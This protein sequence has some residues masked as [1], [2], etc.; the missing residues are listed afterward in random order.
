MKTGAED[1]PAQMAMAQRGPIFSCRPLVNAVTLP[2][3]F[4][5]VVTWRFM[6]RWGVMGRL[7]IWGARWLHRSTR[8]EA[9]ERREAQT[10]QR[11]TSGVGVNLWE[12]YVPRPQCG[13]RAHHG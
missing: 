8:G 1:G 2:S 10:R 13:T 12:G 6:V 7:G 3:W 4:L 11:F 5:L 9:V